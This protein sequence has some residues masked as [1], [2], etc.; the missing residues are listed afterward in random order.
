[1][2]EKAGS[3]FKWRIVEAPYVPIA[4]NASGKVVLIGDAYHGM[5]PHAGEGSS[6]GIEDAAVLAELLSYASSIED[7]NGLMKM[8][9]QIRH[10]RVIAIRRYSDFVGDMFT[11]PDG[12]KQEARDKKL[13][14]FDPN[15]FPDSEP[16]I[17]AKYGSAE[18]MTW[19]D[20]FDVE[21]TVRDA[22][23]DANKKVYSEKARL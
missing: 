9:D 22:L 5:T 4:I 3:H 13:K 14:E 16:N 19:L 18:W 23:K 21:Q 2:F 12:K 11:Y 1:L 20:V 7:I 10:T 8:Y 17:K 15:K 6:M